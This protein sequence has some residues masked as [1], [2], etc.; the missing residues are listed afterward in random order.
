MITESKKGSIA[1]LLT[2]APATLLLIVILLMF[3]AFFFTQYSKP[4]S[5]NI[6]TQQINSDISLINFLKTEIIL[7]NKNM[8]IAELIQPSFEDQNSK[9]A[10]LLKEKYIQFQEINPKKCSYL[11]ITFLENNKYITI[12]GDDYQDI[13]IYRN[14][15]FCGYPR[16]LAFTPV[17]NKELI[18]KGFIVGIGE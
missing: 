11:K 14:L 12:N 17:P 13:E 5:I 16:E 7:N 9:E 18:K 1:D 3:G 4:G 15:H 10:E 6:E 8:L 2:G